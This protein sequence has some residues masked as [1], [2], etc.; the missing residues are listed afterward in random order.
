MSVVVAAALKSFIR[1]LKIDFPRA[2]TPH[3]SP[4][5]LI[6]AG[7]RRLYSCFPHTYWLQ[8]IRG[9]N[10]LVSD[11]TH[12]RKCTEAE[13]A[14][15]V[16]ECVYSYKWERELRKEIKGGRGK[17]PPLLLLNMAWKL[18]NSQ[19]LSYHL[20]FF[21]SSQTCRLYLNLD[22]NSLL[23]L[24]MSAFISLFSFTKI[25][26]AAALTGISRRVH[27]YHNILTDTPLLSLCCQVFI[28]SFSSMLN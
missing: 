9:G 28:L 18:E 23:A 2:P 4:F 27:G 21:C 24:S 11:H 17:K 15:P 5:L 13:R 12:W 7:E 19:L 16:K 10:F 22:T 14:K 3:S 26:A 20:V 25:K 8:L 1:H 6:K